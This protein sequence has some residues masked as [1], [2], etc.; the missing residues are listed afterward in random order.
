MSDKASG[1]I[2]SG[3]KTGSVGG[4]NAPIP[5][6]ASTPVGA[7]SQEPAYSGPAYV[8]NLPGSQVTASII[9]IKDASGILY[10][11]HGLVEKKELITAGL[12]NL[13][14]VIFISTI[15]RIFSAYP[16]ISSI[17]FFFF[18]GIVGAMLLIARYAKLFTNPTLKL[19]VA[20]AAS[21]YW[22]FLIAVMDGQ[23]VLWIILAG[24]VAFALSGWLHLK[25]IKALAN[26]KIVF[27]K[28]QKKQAKG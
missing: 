20:A 13:E 15:P 3:P 28:R 11:N 24:L 10:R 14:L 2:K 16:G 5:T 21:L 18:L 8:P 4:G 26:S 25:A 23:S 9:K 12:L 17:V 22:G 1:S 7:P 27:P 19:P 6:G